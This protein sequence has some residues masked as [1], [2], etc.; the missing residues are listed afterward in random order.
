[1]PSGGR[2]HVPALA[3]K[4]PRQAARSKRGREKVDLVLR[5]MENF[6]Q[7]AGDPPFDFG[8]LRRGLGLD[9]NDG[10]GLD[11]NDGLGL[12]ANDARARKKDHSPPDV[13]PG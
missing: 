3:G 12:D 5:T 6:E 7:R 2:S 8:P 9:A 1:M 10:L 11:A 4:S 13:P